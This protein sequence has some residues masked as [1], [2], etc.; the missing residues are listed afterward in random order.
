MRPGD[1]NA[2]IHSA[3]LLLEPVARHRGI[4]IERQLA[5]DLPEVVADHQALEQVAL[6]LLTN[7]L[8]AVE[9]RPDPSVT[10]ATAPAE[11]PGVS[12]IEIRVTDN[13]SGIPPDVLPH[14][15][16]PFFSTKESPQGAGLGLPI[17]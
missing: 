10:V 4:R 13:G 8:D 7:A 16:E 15:F 17:S 3:C 11:A 5:Q 1:V 14:I 6:N 12:G 9:G 2:G